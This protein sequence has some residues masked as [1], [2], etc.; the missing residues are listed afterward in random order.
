MLLIII[1]SHGIKII[2]NSS[3]AVKC[4]NLSQVDQRAFKARLYH[5]VLSVKLIYFLYFS[6]LTCKTEH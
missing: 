3:L 1:Y 6:R 2:R 5:H 4:S